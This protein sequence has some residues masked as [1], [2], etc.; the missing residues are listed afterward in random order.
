V[1]FFFF[2]FL[3]NTYWELVTPKCLFKCGRAQT[4]GRDGKREIERTRKSRLG[5]KAST[6]HLTSWCSV[7]TCPPLS[8]TVSVLTESHRLTYTIW[9]LARCSH[10]QRLPLRKNLSRVGQG[11]WHHINAHNADRTK[12]NVSKNRV[13]ACPLCG[14]RIFI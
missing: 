1:Q 11:V 8:F 12:A 6:I 5:Y 10:L 14:I 13:E 3:L 9:P 4:K 7:R 2:L